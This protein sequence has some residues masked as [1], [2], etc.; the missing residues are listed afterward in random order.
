MHTQFFHRLAAVAL[1]FASGTIASHFIGA[2]ASAATKPSAAPL[3]AP[4][5]DSDAQCTS[6]IP[7]AWGDFKGGS[8]QSGL[9]FQAPDGTLRF[10]TNV[11]C[12]SEPTVALKIIRTGNGN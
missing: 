5:W 7:R 11:P 10:V 8:T 4:Q 2:R 6:K 9:A 3:S 12:G 1:I